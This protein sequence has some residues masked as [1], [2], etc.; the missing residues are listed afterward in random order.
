MRKWILAA[1]LM[2]VLPTMASAQDVAKGEKVFKKCK[3]CH[4]TDGKNKVGPHLDGVMG[5]AAGAVEGFKYSPAMKEFGKTWDEATMDAYLADPKGYIAKNKMVFVGL[6]K[7][8]DRKDI[9]AYLK[10][11]TK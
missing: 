5:R 7:E 11:L 8:G 1:G 9:I 2:M 6:K 4:A 3:A 10:T